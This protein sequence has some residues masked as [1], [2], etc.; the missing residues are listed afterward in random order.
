MCA[1][2][3]FIR[4]VQFLRVYTVK[5]FRTRTLERFHICKNKFSLKKAFVRYPHFILRDSRIEVNSDLFAKQSIKK[6]RY[7]KISCN[8]RNL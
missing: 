2:K 1:F 6:I 8:N 4:K 3:N 7:Q 5:I